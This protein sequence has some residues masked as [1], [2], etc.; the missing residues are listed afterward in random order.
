[1]R[2][3]YFVH[4]LWILAS[5]GGAEKR[6]ES[7]SA[8]SGIVENTTQPTQAASISDSLS[9]FGQYFGSFETSE[10]TDWKPGGTYRNSISLFVDSMIESK[11]YGH[12]V[13]AGN[14]TPFAGDIVGIEGGYRVTAAEPGTGKYDGRFEFTIDTLK[15]EVA[16]IWRAKD[17]SIA[18]P[19][20]EYT[21]QKRT[22]KYDP[23]L[24]LP[25]YFGFSPIIGL[26][27]Y[28]SGEW[29][30]MTKDVLKF[31]ASTT[32]LKK[33]DVEN[34]K[35]GDLEVMRNAIYA[36]HGYSFRN[37][38][39]RYLFDRVD[40]YMPVSTDIREQLTDIEKQNVAL[41]KRYEEHAEKYY[42]YFGR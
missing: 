16:G 14:N 28:D 27:D 9:M 19:E 32:L 8:D 2:K 42:D 7:V 15:R 24:K 17:T 18:V 31:N 6:A 26:E 12:S 34:M 33:E 10:R 11:V 38:R 40:W 20:R 21:L 23:A 36:R 39:M 5:C 3:S 30:G 29:E 35:H 22:F 25:D 13:V 1:M 37:R 4:L 41:L